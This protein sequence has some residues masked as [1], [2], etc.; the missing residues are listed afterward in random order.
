MANK[1]YKYAA[2][3]EDHEALMGQIQKDSAIN[4][5]LY[6]A[7]KLGEVD[8]LISIQTDPDKDLIKVQN[9]F[10]VL[11][12]Q[13]IKTAGIQMMPEKEGGSIGGES[14]G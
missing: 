9:D 6:V 10:L 4:T 7:R 8:G 2:K 14:I 3:V 11:Y 5:L 1:E 13:L 12:D